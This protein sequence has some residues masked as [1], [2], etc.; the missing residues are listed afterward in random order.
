MAR[1]LNIPSKKRK[2]QIKLSRRLMIPMLLVVALQIVTFYTVLAVGGEFRYVRQYAYNTLV[3]KTENRRNYIESELQQKVPYVQEYSVKI[4]SLIKG[5]LSE[6]N[7]SITALQQD[8]DLDRRIMETSVD[9]MVELL[10]RSNVN[11]VYLILETGDLYVDN[12]NNAK[13]ALY[14]RDLDTNTDAGYEDLLMEVGFTS[15]SRDLGIMLDTG[16]S[17]HFMPDKNN[18]NYDFY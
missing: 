18:N 17:L 7:V 8:R 5:I 9:T 2:R 13:G 4:D 1:D 6:K 3:E 15:I 16:W 11:D 14:L 12:N 10:R